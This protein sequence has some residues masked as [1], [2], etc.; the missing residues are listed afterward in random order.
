MNYLL[1]T[2]ILLWAA[3]CPERLSEQ[4]REIISNME[5]KLYFSAASIWEVSIKNSLGRKDF[6]IDPSLFRRC[7]IENGY[8]E[9]VIESIH[10]I[11]T[12]HLPPLHKDPFNRMLVAQATT[13]GYT[14]LTADSQVAQYP[15]PILL[16]T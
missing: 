1:D 3:S 13:Q 9:M 5:N 16:S 11:T 8:E 4:A 14:L 6:K 2:Q 15:G 12:A 10:A 7:L